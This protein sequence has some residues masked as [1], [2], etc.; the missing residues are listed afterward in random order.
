MHNSEWPIIFSGWYWIL[1]IFL[2][3]IFGLIAKFQTRKHGEKAIK[4]EHY[5]TWLLDL[6]GKEAV[7][8]GRMA[9]LVAEF[10]FWWV[11]L[12]LVG[13]TAIFHKEIF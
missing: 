8:M 13:I 9:I 1:T 6:K 10:L 2:I 5:K 7:K 11:L 12:I 3:V 4:S